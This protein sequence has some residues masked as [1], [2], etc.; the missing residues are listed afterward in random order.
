MALKD[1]I[2]SKKWAPARREE[3]DPFTLFRDEMNRLF[4]SFF[5]TVTGTRAGE[6]LRRGLAGRP[7]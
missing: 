4:D 3:H 1:L 2:P 5:R 7:V 6:E